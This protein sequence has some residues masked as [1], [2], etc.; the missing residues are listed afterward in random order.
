L[1]QEFFV[2][3][4]KFV[5]VDVTGLDAINRLDAELLKQAHEF[6]SIAVS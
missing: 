3:G 5:F 4:E 2:F 6:A 1:L